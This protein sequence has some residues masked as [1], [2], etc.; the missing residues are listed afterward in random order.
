MSDAKRDEEWDDYEPY[1]DDVADCDHEDYEVDILAGRAECN[2]C[3][4]TW[5][6]TT[7]EI[8]REIE[9]WREYDRY[10][11]EEEMREHWWG[12]AWLAVKE[13]WTR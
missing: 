7:E 10:T 13:W 3:G 2:C 1:Y 8:E 6:Q 4:H 5:W 12:R 11:Q 9:R